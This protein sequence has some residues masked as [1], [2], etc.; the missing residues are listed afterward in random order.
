MSKSP[1]KTTKVSPSL[2]RGEPESRLSSTS[3]RR[4]GT[5]VTGRK[6]RAAAELTS[7]TVR[8][9]DV[10]FGD[11]FLLRIP[12][13]EGMKKILIDCGTFGKAP[14]A[15]G[16]IVPSIIKDL[17]DDDGTPRVDVLVV[18]HRHKDHVSGFAIGGWERV[19][20]KEIWMPWT[21]HPTDPAARRIRD[22][23]TR[24]AVALTAALRPSASTP[25]PVTLEEERIQTLLGLNEPANDRAMRTIHHGFAAPSALRRYLPERSGHRVLETS[26]LPGITV[27]LMG[28]SRDEQ[29]I[30]DMEPPAGESYLRLVGDMTGHPAE[31]PPNPFDPDWAI[32]ATDEEWRLP[33]EIVL[34]V[35][36]QD[37]VKRLGARADLAALTALDAAVNG[38]SLMMLF[39]VADA[40]LLFPGDAQWG[41]WRAVLEDPEW[42]SLVGKATFL[43]VGHHASHNATPREFVAEVMRQSI[44]AFVSVRPVGNW[45]SIPRA[46]LLDALREKNV[47]LVRSDELGQPLP[48]GFEA[49]GVDGRVDYVDVIVP[50]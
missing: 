5:A 1:R 30:R 31:G 8:M 25:T 44:P 29:V 7:V 3:D 33:P 32:A 45:P 4:Q 16:D 6:G 17:E 46:E 34:T 38:T 11:C 37:R 42:R 9:Y 35:A 19:E 2:G 26:A 12:T 21:E 41:T 20:V 24:L 36:D 28:P 13:R 14:R 23:Q 22:A 15:M 50:M 47:R 43:K 39:E 18:T 10:G 40:R 27:H 48:N 49:G